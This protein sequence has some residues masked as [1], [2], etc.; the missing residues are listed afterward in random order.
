MR[1][2]GNLNF[3]VE[4][5]YY[6][7]NRPHLLLL[8]ERVS[9]EDTLLS[10]SLISVSLNSRENMTT[11]KLTVQITSFVGSEMI[12]G[13]QGGWTAAVENL[14]SSLGKRTSETS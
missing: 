3:R 8:T 1:P 12:A 7:I 9:R 14:T 6:E 11:L 4:T 10:T 2:K 13:T 5:R